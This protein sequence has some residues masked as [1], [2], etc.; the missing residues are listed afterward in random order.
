MALV[1]VEVHRSQDLGGQGLHPSFAHTRGT[2]SRAGRLKQPRGRCPCQPSPALQEARSGSCA[3]GQEDKPV[4]SQ[5]PWQR[6]TVS[7]VPLVKK[8]NQPLMSS[9]AKLCDLEQVTEPHRASVPP[10]IQW[11]AGRINDEHTKE[12]EEPKLG[13]V[14]TCHPPPPALSQRSSA[15]G[16][17]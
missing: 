13:S 17:Q 4:L 7:H 1:T 11:V 15:Q 10:P 5:F 12:L 16:A 9:G 2:N 3:L 14:S 6:T 8:T